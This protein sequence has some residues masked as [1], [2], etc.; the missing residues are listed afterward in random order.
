[1]GTGFRDRRPYK[2][3]RFVGADSDPSRRSIGV[4]LAAPRSQ[5]AIDYGNNPSSLHR[6]RTNCLRLASSNEIMKEAAR[7]PRRGRLHVRVGSAD[8]C[9][10]HSD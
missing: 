4:C 8:R 7:G 2:L 10:G 9:P 3:G 1:M 5:I 6:H